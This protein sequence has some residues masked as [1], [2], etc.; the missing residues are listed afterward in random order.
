MAQSSSGCVHRCFASG[1]AGTD[2]FMVLLCAR[3]PL[4][5]DIWPLLAQEAIHLHFSPGMRCAIVATVD[6]QSKIRFPDFVEAIPQYVGIPDAM[7]LKR[8][9]RQNAE[10][11]IT[12]HTHPSDKM[13]FIY[14][15]RGLQTHVVGKKTYKMKGG[16][17]LVIFP[18]EKHSSGGTPQEKSLIYWLGL[19]IPKKTDD[20]LSL[21]LPQ[22]R[23][24]ATSLKHI[25]PRHFAGTPALQRHF[26]DIISDMI[27]PQ[28][29]HGVNRSLFVQS[30]LSLFL[31]EALVCAQR[32]RSELANSWENRI[33]K[34]LREPREEP[35]TATTLTRELHVSMS[36]LTIQLKKETGVPPAEYLLRHRL[37][38]A[39]R[40]LD[41]NP[42]KSITEIA[43]ATGF[44]TAQNFATAFKR[45]TGLTP[46]QVRK[47]RSTRLLP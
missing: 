25:S 1:S 27:N 35:L 5:H 20:F 7:Y 8:F 23:L 37:A 33:L 32:R 14:M 6:I 17:V 12:E 47:F 34:L 41:R 16:D 40:L 46:R 42:D 10:G 39:Q 18:G 4:I 44:S 31:L 21:P 43:L 36:S 26:D 15:A 28:M 13:E 3:S 19:R 24:L 30:A 22:S 38:E 45:F 9:Q 2:P 11:P 29:A